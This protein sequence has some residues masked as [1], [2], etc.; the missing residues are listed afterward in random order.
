MRIKT[1]EE[2]QEIV[3]REHD[4]FMNKEKGLPIKL[5]DEQAEQVERQAGLMGAFL[6]VER[7]ATLSYFHDF[8]E[9]IWNYQR[10]H[11]VSGLLIEEIEVD[12]K[13]IRFPSQAYWLILLESDLDILKAAKER[14]VDFFADYVR[15]NLVYLS[16]E[17]YN[18]EGGNWDMQTTLDFIL[19][20]AQDMDWALLSK[21]SIFGDQ[22]SLGLGYGS[23]DEN[24][25]DKDKGSELWYFD[26]S[27][28]CRWSEPIK[29]TPVKMV[30]FDEIRKFR[31]EKDE[32]GEW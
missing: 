24:L 2:L 17:I 25:R 21:G 19:H 28:D 3:Q 14:M 15:N 32:K 13:S 30:G 7:M 18:K 23:A 8:K 10:E 20:F 9:Q 11:E 22:V 5:S 4:S 12:G 27:T 29:A 26:A 16:Y 31:K 1:T 6:G